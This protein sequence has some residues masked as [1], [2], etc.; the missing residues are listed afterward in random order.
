M[1]NETVRPAELLTISADQ[2][3]RT[4]LRAGYFEPVGQGGSGVTKIGA[5]YD[6]RWY[7]SDYLELT[8]QTNG[9]S[10][11]YGNN[12]KLRGE[13]ECLTPWILDMTGRGPEVMGIN[14]VY[15]EKG[16]TAVY[17]SCYISIIGV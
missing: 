9:F 17:A 11:P 10:D 2:Y 14:P 7:T 4:P 5:E 13:V 1:R 15:F 3:A 12:Y 8:P 6:G 16:G